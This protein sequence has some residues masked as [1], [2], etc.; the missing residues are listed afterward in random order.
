MVK[1]LGYKPDYS[2]IST[3]PSYIKR[4]YSIPVLLDKDVGIAVGAFVLIAVFLLS[5]VLAVRLARRARSKPTPVIQVLQLEDV[6]RDFL[7]S[8]GGG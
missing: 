1:I 2:L 3:T 8:I 4:S 6:Q 5:T 7:D